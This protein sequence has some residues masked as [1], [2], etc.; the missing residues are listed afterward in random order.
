MFSSS[1]G[2]Q[3]QNMESQRHCILVAASNPYPLP[4]PVYRPQP[5]HI[6]QSD[7]IETPIDNRLSD[8]EA[9]AKSFAQVLWKKKSSCLENKYHFLLLGIS[10]A[11]VFCSVL[12]LCLLFVQ[13]SYL[14]LELS[15]M[16]YIFLLPRSSY[17][18][19]YCVLYKLVCSLQT[20]LGLSTSC[21]LVL[22]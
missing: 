2:N 7:N 20:R 5:Q 14:N 11:F 8:A 16:R 13:R 22:L 4:T 15:I 17:F 18:S 6:E 9:I 12:S 19:S 21:S 3:N 1:N 10:A